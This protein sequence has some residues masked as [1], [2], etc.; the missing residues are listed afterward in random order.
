MS[1]SEPAKPQESRRSVVVGGK[2]RLRGLVFLATIIALIG[3]ALAFDP[4][5]AFDP[6][7]DDDLC[8]M[9]TE[10]TAS[11][12]FLVDLSKPLDPD[13]RALPGAV[14]HDVSLGLAVG[15]ELRVFAVARTPDAPREYLGRACKPYANSDLQVD[16]AKDQRDRPRDCDD[17]PAQISHAVRDAAKRYCAR[18][19]V[20]VERVD[21][22]AD[23]T[24]GGP[25]AN[26]YLIEALE[27][28]ALEF[29]E[30]A[31]PRQLY[32][33]SDLMQ[34]AAWYSHFDLGWQWWRFEDFVTMRG[35]RPGAMGPR[36]PT[37]DIDVTLFYIGRRGLNDQPQPRRALRQ[38]WCEYFDPAEPVFEEQP[39]MEHYD[40]VPLMGVRTEADRMRLMLEQERERL[41]AE[42]ERQAREARRL[43]DLEAD[44]H[45]REEQLRLRAAALPGA[46]EPG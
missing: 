41:D 40:A 8:P 10:P 30:R 29:E 46:S 22:L 5:V 4:D 11:A 36:P 39:M 25:V 38:F 43:A 24:G 9:D 32:V 3:F 37:A 17:V 7:L 14:L 1:E 45:R 16:Q 33:V 34:H 27:D 19:D 23:S 28:T 18:R 12:T 26:A 31:G 2:M 15:T 42:R 20:L 35:K 44:L 21:A 13:H 6:T